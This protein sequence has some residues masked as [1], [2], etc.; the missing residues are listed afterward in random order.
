MP[1]FRSEHLHGN[2]MTEQ[3]DRRAERY[4]GKSHDRRYGRHGRSQQVEPLIGSGRPDILLGKHLDQ[5]G[6]RLQKAVRSNPVRS[7]P[8][9]HPGQDLPLGK[10]QVG[11]RGQDHGVDK[12]QFYQEQKYV[13]CCKCHCSLTCGICCNSLNIKIVI[14]ECYYRGSRFLVL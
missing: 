7:F 9:L 12:D 8:V 4:H 5:V 2:S 6:Q 13:D 3:G 11:G 1:I 14:P 10:D